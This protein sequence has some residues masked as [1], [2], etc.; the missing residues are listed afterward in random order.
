MVQKYASHFVVFLLIS[1]WKFPFSFRAKNTWTSLCFTNNFPVSGENENFVYFDAISIRCDFKICSK[2][3]MVFQSL[4]NWV[5]FCL[6][7]FVH[8]FH[9][10]RINIIVFF[11]VAALTLSV[12]CSFVCVRVCCSSHFISFQCYYCYLQ[13]MVSLSL[14][15]PAWSV[16][17]FVRVSVSVSAFNMFERM[18]VRTEHDINIQCTFQV[19]MCLCMLPTLV[20]TISIV[21][22]VFNWHF[23][24][25]L[26]T[27]QI[28]WIGCFRFIAFIRFLIAFFDVHT[29]CTGLD[30]WFRRTNIFT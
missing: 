5:G 18:C 1:Q 15:L 24:V 11:F 10:V 4:W 8:L 23:S 28:I 9:F 20:R 7:V 17:V 27:H 14:S 21:S 19:C 26:T 16:L 25:K 22:A 12:H 3:V 30:Y 2:I 6:F 13:L 29:P